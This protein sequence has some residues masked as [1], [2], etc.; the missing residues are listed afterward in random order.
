M[1]QYN[2]N[3]EFWSSKTVSIVG[4][5]GSMGQAMTKE[6]LNTDVKNIR[7]ISRDEYK[8]YRMKEDFKDLDSKNRIH[9]IL[10]DMRLKH[11]MDKSLLNSDVVFSVGANKDVGTSEHNPDS[12]FETNVLGNRNIAEVCIKHQIPIMIMVST[13]KATDPTTFYGKTKA[14]AEVIVMK[15]NL[16]KPAKFDCK[17]GVTRCGNLWASRRSVIETFDRMYAENPECELRITDERMTRFF[18]SIERSARYQL[19][20]AELLRGDEWAAISSLKPFVPEIYACKL[21]DIIKGRYP[22]AKYNIVGAHPNEKLYESFG[23]DYRSDNP[24][25]LKCYPEIL[26]Y[27]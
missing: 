24:K 27:L 2:L 15:A 5:T 8:H 12:A 7:I 26:E 9:Y 3:P 17:F 10:G 18:I 19:K 4:G 22:K 25:Y 21:M 6:L 20:C 14:M 13:D 23:D 1:E 16:T 11:E